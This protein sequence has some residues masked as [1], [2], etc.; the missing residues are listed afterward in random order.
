MKLTFTDGQ[1][2]LVI[3]EDIGK[4]E[5]SLFKNQYAQADKILDN[6][7]GDDNVYKGRRA[8]NNI[9]A[10]CGDRGSGKTSCMESFRLQIEAKSKQDYA[11]SIQGKTPEEIKQISRQF[12]FLNT[13]DP[14]FFDDTHNILE[15]VLGSMYDNIEEKKEENPELYDKVLIE[16]NK[17][18]RYLKYLAAPRD[19]EKF[20]DALQEL[21]SLSAGLKLQNSI[22]I[23][24]RM[25]LDLLGGKLLVIT[26]D[27]LDLNIR[28][29]YKMSEHIRKYLTNENCIILL[30]VKVDQLVDAIK[31]NIT[32]NRNVSEDEGYAMAVKYATKLLPVGNR[33]NMPEL[34][35]Y[36]NYEL[37]YVIGNDTKTYNSVKESVVLTIFWKTGYLF[38]NS[39]G[40][41]SLIIP[42]N[43]RSLRQ[44]LH[45]L[46]SLP[47]HDKTKPQQWHDSQKVFKNYFFKTWTQQLS[48]KYGHV[49]SMI[50]ANDNNITFNKTVVL[51][52]A[53]IYDKLSNNEE[54]KNITDPSNYAYNVSLGDV[55][56]I[57]EYLSQDESD[58]QLQLLVFFIRSLY[59]M[60]LYEA[61]DHI[62]EDMANEHYPVRP[63]GI[64]GEIYST[65]ALFDKANVLQRLLNGQYFNFENTP[66]IARESGSLHSRGFLPI[67]GNEISKA[68]KDFAM[69]REEDL[70][71]AMKNRFKTIE[72]F[73]LTTSRH[74]RM[75]KPTDP[76]NKVRT[77][78]DP[79]HL[80]EFTANTKN[81]IFDVMSIFYNMVNLKSTY[82]RFN[83]FFKLNEDD[84][85]SLYEYAH[86][87]PWSLLSTMIANENREY[88]NP[89]HGLLSDAVLRNAEVINAISELVKSNRYKTSGD[90]NPKKIRHFYNSIY[91]T[92]MSTYRQDGNQNPHKIELN[93]LNSVMS[94]LDHC[95]TDC[96]D[97]IYGAWDEN[98]FLAIEALFTA[99]SYAHST[100]KNKLRTGRPDIYHIIT[101]AQWN[102]IFPNGESSAS[103]DIVRRIN[104]VIENQV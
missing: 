95:D 8:S 86:S 89:L 69:H 56:N 38:Y 17:V 29:A 26:I 58:N 5:G 45:L 13:I 78:S 66:V 47:P 3:K 41:S 97:K 42:R 16:F 98:G 36:C 51:Q 31:L 44:L 83:D 24:M 79:H 104:E 22:S 6:L 1:E 96:F 40:R 23:L 18:M 73:M 57:L 71:E 50:L 81:L 99:N 103:R 20:Y 52:L 12:L 101:P 30:S 85:I 10:F 64:E 46:I 37:D 90:T 14:S 2:N 87:K 43:L 77:S 102:E 72:F 7:S 53:S 15:L 25:Y 33:V 62:T 28:G 39:K 61:Y 67:N 55:L 11:D 70:D 59:S 92:G 34:E 94:V 21:E 19:K 27:D 88:V 48:D 82:D 54:L 84:G 76:I 100:V 74:Q 91:N 32:A 80:M 4:K 60:K 35:D 93:F 75:H 63:D 9:I 49:V 68:L 65:D